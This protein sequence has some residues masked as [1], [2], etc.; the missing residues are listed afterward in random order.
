MTVKE[1]GELARE[2]EE[3][4][5]KEKRGQRE[6]ERLASMPPPP[7]PEEKKQESSDSSSESDDEIVVTPITYDKYSHEDGSK[8][9]KSK[10]YLKSQKTK[11]SVTDMIYTHMMMI[12]N[13]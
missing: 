10:T 7:P 11:N 4:R 8:K 1:W 13:Y 3:E 5:L 12:Q 2:E 6:A 9:R